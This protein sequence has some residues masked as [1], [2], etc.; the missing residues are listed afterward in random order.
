MNASANLLLLCLVISLT[1]IG[2]CGRPDSGNHSRD[3]RDAG[4]PQ[5]FELS[6]QLVRALDELG[7]DAAALRVSAEIE[8]SHTERPSEVGFEAL[9][10]AMASLR[11]Q[12]RVL[13]LAAEAAEAFPDNEKFRYALARSSY[14]L[15]F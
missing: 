12:R 5:W 9:V 6:A 7:R 10:D 11:D 3:E 14:W 8:A 15:E 4:E 2:A 13:E 1:E